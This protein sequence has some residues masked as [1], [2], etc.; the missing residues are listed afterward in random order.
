[1]AEDG[2]RDRAQKPVAG[3]GS[4]PG[5]VSTAVVGL[6]WWGKVVGETLRRSSRFDLVMAVDLDP[7]TASWAE[8]RDLDFTTDLAVAVADER[9]QAVMLCTP[10]A[11]HPTQVAQVAEGGKHV[12]CEKP[13]ALSRAGAVAAVDACTSNGVRLGIGHEKRF[14]PPTEEV[15]ELV[16]SGRLGTI[17]QFEGVLSQN[18]FI[19]LPEDNWRLSD[20][21]APAG[22][23]TATAIHLV[24]LS[25]G[26]LGPAHSA[27]AFLR[28]LGSKLPNGDT[29]GVLVSYESGAVGTITAALA[30]PY[31]GRFAVYGNE[32]WAEVRDG[33][34]HAVS[35]PWKLTTSLAGKEQTTRELAAVD[36]VQRNLEAFAASIT[37]PASYPI[38]TD[39]MIADTALAEAIIVSARSGALVSV[40]S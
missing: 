27:I 13:L 29:L 20:E 38:P 32:G 36:T 5:L 30:T 14:E 24:D 19:A 3:A 37:G 12:F 25:V 39:D 7:S 31:I 26:L 1:M 22:P 11:E 28:Q 2:E 34:Q 40:P 4:G 17:L 9:V 10:P 21:A 23:L 18:R 15:F 6:G 33:S 16:R 8:D 35:G